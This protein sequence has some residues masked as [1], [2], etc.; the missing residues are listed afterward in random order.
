MKVTT[1]IKLSLQTISSLLYELSLNC[2]HNYR[3][4][5]KVSSK[6]LIEAK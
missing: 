3:L 1:A 6:W 2:C 5:I 4:T